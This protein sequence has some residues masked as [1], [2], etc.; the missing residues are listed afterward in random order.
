MPHALLE[1]IYS[2]LLRFPKCCFRFWLPP[3]FEFT[4]TSSAKLLK[5]EQNSAEQSESSLK[6]VNSMQSTAL[7]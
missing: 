5:S 4:E 3:P 2:L 1:G 6:E 7:D